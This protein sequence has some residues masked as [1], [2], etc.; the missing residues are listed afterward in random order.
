[1]GRTSYAN[2]QAAIYAQLASDCQ[3]LLEKVT[4]SIEDADNYT[5]SN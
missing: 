1:M 5:V 4:S 2:R 3:P